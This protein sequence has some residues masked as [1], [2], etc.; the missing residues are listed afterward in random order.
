MSIVFCFCMTIAAGVVSK[1]AT[2]FMVSQAAADVSIEACSDNFNVPVSDGT[3]VT[4]TET[5]RVGW[6]WAIFFCFLAG[7]LVTFIR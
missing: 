1:G 7:E 3:V 6:I 5:E 4:L 2:F